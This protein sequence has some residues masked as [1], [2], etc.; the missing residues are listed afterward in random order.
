MHLAIISHKKNEYKCEIIKSLD[1]DKITFCDHADFTDLC[2]GG[3]IPSTKFIKSVKLLNTAGAYW[4]GDE[5]NKQ[6]TRI[7]GISFPKEKLLK[8]YLQLIDEAKK[9]D[10]RVIGKKLGLFTF[11][12]NVGLGLPLWLPEGT[13]LRSRLE[14]FLKTAQ[15]KA[16]YEMVIT[17]HIGNKKLYVQSGHYDKYGESTFFPIKTPKEDEEFLLKPMSNGQWCRLY[18]GNP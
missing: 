16:G 4:R 12:E 9:R 2:K 15:K 14:E 13:E 1:N 17:P 18:D 7:Y 5:N 6:L 8:E 3:H 10:H 11:S